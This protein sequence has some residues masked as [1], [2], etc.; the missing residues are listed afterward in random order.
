MTLSQITGY[1]YLQRATGTSVDGSNC[2]SKA[3]KLNG[4]DWDDTV[5]LRQ[6]SWPIG[7]Q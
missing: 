1:V 7:T 3:V 5:A 2:G 4:T 6:N